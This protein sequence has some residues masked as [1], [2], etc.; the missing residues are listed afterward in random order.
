MTDHLEIIRR[1][2]IEMNIGFAPLGP[3]QSCRKPAVGSR[4]CMDC[5]K[6]DLRQLVQRGD[7]AALVDD[8]ESAMRNQRDA[9]RAIE[10]ACTPEEDD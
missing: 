6:G 3:C 2:R 8:L 10:K 5:L 1:M 4:R 7:P 9:L